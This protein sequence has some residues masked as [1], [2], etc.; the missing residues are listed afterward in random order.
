MGVGAVKSHCKPSKANK[1]GVRVKTKHEKAI[2][3]LKSMKRFTFTDSASASSTTASTSITPTE[4]TSAS[5]VQI[6]SP[7]SSVPLFTSNPTLKAEIRLAMKCVWSH[8][9]HR[10]LD[11]YAD[12]FRVIFPDSGIAK[13]LQLGRTK[14]GYVI[15]FGLKRYYHDKMMEKLKV[16]KYYTV[17]FDEALNNISN[18]KQLDA[19][20]LFFNEDDN[21]VE[22][23]YIGSSF[24]GHGDAEL[25]LKKLIATMNGLDYVYKLVQVSMDG[26]HVNWKLHELLVEDRNE[27]STGSAPTLL[28]LG[29][30]GLHVLHGAFGTGQKATDWGLAKFLKHCYSIF[31]HS[32]ARRADYLAS[33]DLHE[34]HEGR[35]TAYLFPL[36]FCGHRWL[37]NSPAITRLLEILPY[38][39][40]YFIWLV[41]H[42]KM[43]K[44]DN[45]FTHIKQKL[46]WCITEPML[47]FSLCIMNELDPILSI[48][49]SEKP[50]APFLYGSFK[51]VVTSLLE[52][53]VRSDILQNKLSKVLNIDLAADKNMLPSS[54]V[55]VGFAA[56]NALK[57]L[58]STVQ[59]T[60]VRKFRQQ[61]RNMIVALIRKVLERSPLK[62]PLSLFISSLSP[63][64]IRTA[65]DEMLAKRFGK[66]MEMLS[67]SKWI[68]CASA[69]RAL[70]QYK[71]L[72]ADGV[73]ESKFN[74]FSMENDRLDEFYHGVFGQFNQPCEELKKV[75]KLILILSHG[76]ARV[77]S[78]FS[79]NKE[80]LAV[81]LL[82]Q[83]LVAQ[84]IVFEGILKEGGVL[85]A[86]INKKMI[87]H[88]K[89]AWR[90]ARIDAE[91]RRKLQT[92]GDKKR[93]E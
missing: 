59:V 54:S 73:L 70:K 19:H 37:K 33:N 16:A 29:S 63:T 30:C 1:D 49:Q 20:V 91:E 76:N 25:C 84:R 47:K 82:E 15:N 44:D 10:S 56:S 51:D 45:R 55:N 83:S 67:S 74:D 6:A 9:S 12:I 3:S 21:K 78:G 7:T 66:L 14:V 64:Q 50:L 18:R 28:Q 34:K 93:E 36:K 17:C 2:E 4:E 87:E 27:V 69:E 79:I 62:Y 72:L 24:M 11:D 13:E 61:A 81:N 89:K 57:K 26:P 31:N 42:K 86:D 8:Y 88:V 22:R 52:R 48:F 92:E 46:N 80:I 68:T 35:D 40:K 39:K 85:N 38:L 23:Y 53:A 41:E 32:P 77:E 71:L 43:P 75:V 58:T 60:E 65:P 5:P 90:Y